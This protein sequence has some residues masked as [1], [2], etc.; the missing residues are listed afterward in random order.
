MSNLKYRLLAIAALVLV[1]AWSLWPRTTIER[2]NRGGVITFDTIS[3]VPLKRGLDL[4]GGMHLALEIDDSRGTVA[5]PA[6]ALSRAERVVRNRIDQF[7]VAEP[8]VQRVGDDRL[9]VELPGIDDPQRAIELV[10][11]SGFLQF[12][13]TDKTN[14]LERVVPRLD[15]IARELGL[16]APVAGGD[17][18]PRTAVGGVMSGLLDTSATAAT[19]SVGGDSAAAGRA[20]DSAAAI[21]ALTPGASGGPFQRSLNAGQIPGQ[22]YVALADF[23]LLE[24]LLS[25]PEI[26]AALP[27]GKQVKWGVDSVALGAG[28]LYRPLYV[29]DARPIITGEALIDARPSQSGLDGPAVDFQLNNEGGRRFR[30]ETGRHINDNMAIVLDDRVVSAPTINSA[31]GTRGQITLGV[32]ANLQEAQDLAL[33]LRAG[34]LPVPLQVAEVRNIGPSLGQDAVD[35]GVRAG[36]LGVFLVILIMIIYYKFS[37]VLAVAGLAMFTLFTL[38][39]LAGLDAVLTL[40]GIA[41]FVLS[42]GMAVDANF[43]IFERIREELDAGR[44]VRAAVDSGFQNA[45]SAI[46]D[47]NAT[48]AITAAVLYQFGTGPVRGFAVTLL[49]GIA[50]SMVTAIFVVRTFFLVWLSRKQ[51]PQ[52]LSI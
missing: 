28:Q 36:L 1:S 25:R 21:P 40:P 17:T 39:M 38:A 10:Q 11:Q 50:A 37:G 13:I 34:S 22:F 35:S 4:R 27:P 15:A 33:V 3:R 45:L 2:V 29:L 43:L 26:I 47:S 32:G 24:A 8:V 30:V 46:I 44:T 18:A 14:A 9:I 52:T 7:G 49:A 12:Q 31:I 20:A 48:T 41:G 16:A 5:D 23:Q 6:D 42:I 19:D 51:T